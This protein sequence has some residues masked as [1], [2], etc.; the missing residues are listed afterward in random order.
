VERLPALHEFDSQGANLAFL[1]FQVSIRQ[2]RYVLVKL[3][4]AC[5]VAGVPGGAL[6]SFAQQTSG[7]LRGVV[8]NRATGQPIARV[9]VS[10]SAAAAAVLTDG[11][12]RF[13]FPD[14]PLGV[15]QLRYHRPGYLDPLSGR[16]QASRSMTLTA[17][18]SEQVLPLDAAAALHGQL[19]PGDGASAAGMMVELYQAHVQDGRRSWQQAQMVRARADGSFNF[20]NL[21]PGSYA[22]HVEASEDP[23]PP[24]MPEGRRTGYAPVFAPN[25]SDIASATVYTLQPG[26]VEE[27]RL[28]VARVPFYPVSVRVAGEGG[29]G[30]FQVSGSGFTR[31]PM[32]Y[33]REDD[34]LRTEL[35]S[36]NYLLQA[37]GGGRQ[38]GQ[39]ELALHV[40][41]AAVSGLSISLIA[42]GSLSVRSDAVAAGQSSSSATQE[43][44]PRVTLLNFLPA[45][46]STRP[47]SGQALVYEGDGDTSAAQPGPGPGRYWV[48][49]VASG[50][51]V[52]TLTSGGTNLFTEPLT[53][54]SGTGVEIEA[55]IRQ[56]GGT[57]S[58]VLSGE[59]AEQPCV[60]QLIPLEP[61]GASRSTT[62]QQ[63]GATTSFANVPPGDYLVVATERRAALAFLEPGVLAQ[64]TGA[65]VTVTASG[66]A[67]AAVS[68][69]FEPPAGTTGA[70]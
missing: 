17:N 39:G 43:S 55:S 63:V 4:F 46:D 14:V 15:V 68:A 28:R 5:M 58:V 61:G 24:G 67:Q 52:A 10:P 59:P 51:Y 9:M 37:G 30:S 44:A 47:I 65:R 12:G 60:L 48:S 11:A 27:V 53:V 3:A 7:T 23:V 22:V 54:I 19:S 32:R 50:G 34:A 40:E 8:V 31:W 35:P 64:L 29:G 38:G 45:G 70:P 25:T 57:V 13:S 16:E 26:Q 33:S 69:F 1:L 42:A 49:A 62:V 21:R 36:G 6:L 56:D 20:L 2:R 41:G 18:S 66:T